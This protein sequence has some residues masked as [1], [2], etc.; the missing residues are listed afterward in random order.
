MQDIQIIEAGMFYLKWCYTPCKQCH[1]MSRV[2]S[3][4]TSGIL[5]YL[6]N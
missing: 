2:Y 6:S 5:L 1:V 4:N 3:R